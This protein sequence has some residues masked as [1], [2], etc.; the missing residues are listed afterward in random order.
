MSVDKDYMKASKRNV[1]SMDVAVTSYKESTQ[2]VVSSAIESRS[3]YVCVS[4]VHMCMEVY[5]SEVFRSVVNNADL[6]VP[7]G[8]PLA[9]ALKLLGEKGATQVRGS[10]LLLHVCKEAEMMQV[11]IGLYGGTENSLTDF[12]SFLKNEFPTLEIAYSYSP[13]FRELTENEKSDCVKAIRES[14][15]RIMFVGIGCPKQERWMA[16]HK[17][18]IDCV[19]LGVGAAFDFFSGRKKHAPRWMQ[20]AGLEWFFRLCSD[21]VRLFYRY[22]KH[23]PRFIYYFGKQLLL[24]KLHLV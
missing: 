9:W 15:A 8:K 18:K 4:N 24:E 14:G 10:D 2:F 22:G 19:M 1:V 12:I 11:P 3:K 5:D 17:G 13:P 7:D 6:V 16:E 20:N 21:P 23:N